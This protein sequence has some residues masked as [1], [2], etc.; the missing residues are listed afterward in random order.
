[1]PGSRGLGRRLAPANRVPVRSK[2]V[3]EAPEPF[4]MVSRVPCDGARRS[5]PSRT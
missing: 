2:R 1:M 4:W 5:K 3:A